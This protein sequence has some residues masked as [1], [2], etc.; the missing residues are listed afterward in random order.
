MGCYQVEFARSATK[1]LRKVDRSRI[2]QI[3]DRVENL[4]MD[5]VLQ[6]ARSSPDP[7]GHFESE[8]E[9]IVSFTKWKMTSWLC[10]L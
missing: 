10:S 1:D 4:A 3:L 2:Q 6:D 8:W 7:N 9:T 5:P